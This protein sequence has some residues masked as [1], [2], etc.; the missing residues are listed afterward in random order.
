M[1]KTSKNGNFTYE[2]DIENS[3]T[4]LRVG[5][6]TLKIGFITQDGEFFLETDKEQVLIHPEHLTELGNYIQLLNNKYF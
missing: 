3:L 2:R 6:P 1:K 5:M 4:I